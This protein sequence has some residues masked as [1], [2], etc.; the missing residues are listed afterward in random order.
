MAGEAPSRGGR[1]AEVSWGFHGLLV[2]S[3]VFLMLRWMMLQMVLGVTASWGQPCIVAKSSWGSVGMGWI[4]P[5]SDLWP[6]TVQMR[7]HGFLLD[8]IL[9]RRAGLGG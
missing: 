8:T 2:C 3:G 1:F 9:P 5:Y 6:A 7:G 4:A